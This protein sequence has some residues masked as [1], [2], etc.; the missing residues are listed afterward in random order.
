MLFLDSLDSLG[1]HDSLQFHHFSQFCLHFDYSFLISRWIISYRPG[2]LW[3]H[4]QSSISSSCFC[5]IDPP[6]PYS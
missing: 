4:R 5:K 2:L 6:P 1:S 3:L